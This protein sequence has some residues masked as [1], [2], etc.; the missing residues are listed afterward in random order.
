MRNEK[1]ETVY[2]KRKTIA[3]MKEGLKVEA[4]GQKLDIILSIPLISGKD[5]LLKV[6]TVYSK[7]IICEYQL[8]AELKYGCGC[9]LCAHSG[10]KLEIAVP[11]VEP[12]EISH[13]DKEEIIAPEGV[14]I[15]LNV[16]NVVDPHQLMKSRFI[17]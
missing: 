4:G 2:L 12:K 17:V 3:E 16:A 10:P 15:K 5:G 13:E 7:N 11:V 8:E 1:G 6:P 9:C 14:K